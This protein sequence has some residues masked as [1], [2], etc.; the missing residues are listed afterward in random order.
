M[1]N[2]VLFTAIYA[3][4]GGALV[5]FMVHFRLNRIERQKAQASE[6]LIR[7]RKLVDDCAVYLKDGETPAQRIER[8]RNE[9]MTLLSMLSIEKNHAESLRAE[10]AGIDSVLAR[11]P[12]LNKATRR[13]NI[14][15]AINTAKHESDARIRAEHELDQLR[16]LVSKDASSC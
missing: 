6:E 2:E 5:A 13:D 11:R 10:L 12:A 4:A 3:L 14:E 15:H 16:R 9:V 1:T 7:L 8:E